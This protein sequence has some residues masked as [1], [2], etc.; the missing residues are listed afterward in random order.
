MTAKA[1]RPR[2]E[3]A[4]D[5]REEG[6]LRRLWPHTVRLCRFAFQVPHPLL[7]IDNIIS[8]SKGFPLLYG[9]LTFKTVWHDML[10]MDIL[11]YFNTRKR[12]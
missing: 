4:S 9:G 10:G 1:V 8:S 3:V 11:I 12:P 6:K 5:V 7:Y 2:L